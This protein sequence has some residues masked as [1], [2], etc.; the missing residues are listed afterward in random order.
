MRG[1]ASVPLFLIAF[2]A[3]TQA[4]PLNVT[5]MALAAGWLPGRGFEEWSVFQTNTEMAAACAESG[6]AWVSR[7]RAPEGGDVMA[8]TESRCECRG[9][10]PGQ[11]WCD[12]EC[13][14][15][16]CRW[17][18]DSDASRTPQN[19]MLCGALKMKCVCW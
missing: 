11:G 2:A 7:V 15:P 5:H 16:G 19:G 13:T 17:T 12:D 8:Y 14:A 18:G 9:P 4:A 10:H 3:S 6:C 1:V